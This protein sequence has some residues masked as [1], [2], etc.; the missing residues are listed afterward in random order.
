MRPERQPGD[1]AEGAAAA[2]ALERPG[3]V[4]MRAGVGDPHRAVGGDELGLQGC[5]STAAL[6]LPSM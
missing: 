6:R 1:D 5:R 3:Q 4:G 2:T